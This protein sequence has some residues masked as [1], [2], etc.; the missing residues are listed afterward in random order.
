MAPETKVILSEVIV[1]KRGNNL[2]AQLIYIYIYNTRGVLYTF[3]CQF[4]WRTATYSRVER[5]RERE[6]GRRDTRAACVSRARE[7]AGLSSFPHLLTS[8][9]AAWLT[10]LLPKPRALAIS[11]SVTWARRD[12]VFRFDTKP[13]RA[14]RHRLWGLDGEGYRFQFVGTGEG[15]RFEGKIGE[16]ENRVFRIFVFFRKMSR[17]ISS[18]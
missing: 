8:N 14:N 12:T 5:E 7:R 4:S 17:E 16:N 11:Y 10:T 6:E 1:E 13:R 15:W 3:S 9:S 2:F 18:R